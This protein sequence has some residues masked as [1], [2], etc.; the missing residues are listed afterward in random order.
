MTGVPSMLPSSV[1]TGICR[2]RA[3]SYLDFH[4]PESDRAPD[5]AEWASFGESLELRDMGTDLCALPAGEYCARG[6]V[7]LGC[8]SAQP[9]RS[10]VPVFRKMLTSHEHALARARDHEPA[11]QIAA[12]ELEVE[13]ITGA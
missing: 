8:N 7:C 3:A 10:A 13:R 1:V 12:R 2:A 5:A 9:K 4:G 11:G 6:L